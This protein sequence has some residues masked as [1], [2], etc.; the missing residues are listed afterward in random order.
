MWF[1]NL[2]ITE[3][4]WQ[5][6]LLCCAVMQA[7]SVSISKLDTENKNISCYTALAGILFS[8]T[9]NCLLKALLTLAHIARRYFHTHTHTLRFYSY[10]CFMTLSYGFVHSR[11]ACPVI[12]QWIV[13]I[14]SLCERERESEECSCCSLST[15]VVG[16]SK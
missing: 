2:S 1:V 14:V 5:V 3:G 6:L 15:A 16:N 4:L 7:S 12:V 11:A 9:I 8:A 10:M 13:M